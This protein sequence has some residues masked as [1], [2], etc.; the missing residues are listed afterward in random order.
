MRLETKTH[1]RHKMSFLETFNAIK[2]NVVQ[3]CNGGWQLLFEFEN[4]YGASVVEHSYSYG[5]ELA[6]IEYNHDW[7]GVR[8]FRSSDAWDIVYDTPITNDVIGHIHEVELITLL[9]A[10]RDLPKRKDA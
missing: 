5:V 1:E 3:A 7:E 10:I 9:H 2:P 6:V 8:D 4:G